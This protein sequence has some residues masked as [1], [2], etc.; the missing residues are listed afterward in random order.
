LFFPVK[1]FEVKWSDGPY[2]HLA[3]LKEAVMF[4]QSNGLNKIVVTLKT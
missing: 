1:A 2:D 4:A 3:E